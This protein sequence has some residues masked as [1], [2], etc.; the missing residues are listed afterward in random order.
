[1]LKDIDNYWDVNLGAESLRVSKDL[2]RGK[3]GE[4]A[5]VS[6]AEARVLGAHVVA[7]REK[8]S[9]SFGGIYATGHMPVSLRG[10]LFYV[11]ID[12]RGDVSLPMGLDQMT[13]VRTD[14]SDKVGNFAKY[15]VNEREGGK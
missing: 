2:F 4:G 5:E 11:E 12:S 1:M 8:T 13:P 6:E 3:D 7:L 10:G 14:A 15:P 9:D